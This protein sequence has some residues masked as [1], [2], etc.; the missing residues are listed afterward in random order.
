MA[1]THALFRGIAA[2]PDVRMVNSTLAI[3]NSSCMFA[4]LFIAA[5]DGRTSRL[6]FEQVCSAAPASDWRIR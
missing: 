4:A 3:T 5:F 6:A 2:R 1:R